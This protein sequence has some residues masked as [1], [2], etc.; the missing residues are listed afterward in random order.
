MYFVT[1]IF[2]RNDDT[3]N[4]ALSIA[5]IGNATLLKKHTIPTDALFN[6]RS[7]SPDPFLCI[8]L[9]ICL[10]W[11]RLFLLQPYGLWVVGSLWNPCEM[12]NEY[13][14]SSLTI[15]WHSRPFTVGSQIRLDWI[16]L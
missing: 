11:H 16:A 2:G 6:P 9:R 8:I 7:T 5:C 10:Q 4:V 1:N 15:F 14:V 12:T 3:I 13:L